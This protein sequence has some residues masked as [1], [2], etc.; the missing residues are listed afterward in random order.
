[1]TKLLL[2]WVVVC[3]CVTGFAPTAFAQVPPPP[4]PPQGAQP[5]RP[6]TPPPPAAALLRIFLDCNRCDGEYMRQEITF[7]DYMRDRRDADVHV[8]VTT[9][10]TGGGGTEYTLKFIGLGSFA[11]VDQTLR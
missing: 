10:E 4:P 5:G 8:L 2:K 7:V 3:A 6:M 11:G 1:M 9:Q